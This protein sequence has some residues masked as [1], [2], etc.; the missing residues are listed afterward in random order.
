MGGHTIR[1]T[2]VQTKEANVELL[3]DSCNVLYT[4]TQ[5]FDAFNVMSLPVIIMMV[6]T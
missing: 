4:S 2:D 6:K 1:W 3:L 5:C